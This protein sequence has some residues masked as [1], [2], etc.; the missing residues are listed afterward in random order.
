MDRHTITQGGLSATILAQGAELCS[1]HSETSGE[2]MWQAGPEWPRHAPVLF[3]VVGRLKND[4]LMH[5]GHDYR[6]TQHG[7]ARDSRFAFTNHAADHCRLSLHDTEATRA[8]FPFAFVFE[9]DFAIAD[10]TLTVTYTSTNSAVAGGETLPVSQG[11]HPAFRWPLAPNA[12]KSSHILTFEQDEP[13]PMPRVAGGLLG[14]AIH[15]SVVH[16]HVLPLNET[17]FATD[18]LILPAAQSHW[19]RYTAPEAP[20][21]LEMTWQNFPSFGIWMKPGADFLCLEPWHG[22]ASPEDWDGVFASKPGITLLAPGE[23][24]VSAYS[25]RLLEARL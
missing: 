6:M 17:L 8:I 21:G 4:T 2:M 10:S 13:A 12:A 7:F 22:M 16:D 19:V 9:L 11:A 25:L 1:L 18:A 20:V 15:P 5:G 3:P 23:S 14:P 24:L